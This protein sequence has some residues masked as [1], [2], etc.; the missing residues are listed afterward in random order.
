MAGLR[1]NIARSYTSD[2]I[3]NLEWFE[4]NQQPENFKK[5]LFALTFFHAV[6][7]ER[8]QFGPLGWNIRYEFNET[9]LRISV[10]QLYMFLNEYEDVQ[11]VALRY[12]TG[13]CNYGGRVTDDWDRRCLNTILYKFYNPKALTQK[14]YKLDPSGVYY[15]PT[16][17]EHSDFIT[18]A[19]SLPL[20]TPPSVFGFHSNADI[21]KHFQEASLLL[22]TAILTQVR[23]IYKKYG[24]HLLDI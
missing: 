22:D 4:G 21:T 16:L 12:L 20:Q 13:E 10:T 6:V 15:I 9:D 19:R 2:P 1:A 17:K 14:N 3:N 18:Y 8:R 11:F 23:S 7:Q 24:T 5:L